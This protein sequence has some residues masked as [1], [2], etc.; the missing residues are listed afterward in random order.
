MLWGTA[1]ERQPF[2][3]LQTVE[4]GT[5]NPTKNTPARDPQVLGI[6]ARFARK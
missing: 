2:E 6:V 3:D 5:R 4:T 1:C